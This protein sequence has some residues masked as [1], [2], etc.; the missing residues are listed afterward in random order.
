M[1]LFGGVKAP[2]RGESSF[3]AT[4]RNLAFYEGQATKYRLAFIAVGI[5]VILGGV[6]IAT[7]AVLGLDTTGVSIIGAAIVLAEASS[8]FFQVQKRY[9]DYRITAEA[10]RLAIED[11]NALKERKDRRPERAFDDL[12]EIRRQEVTKWAKLTRGI[13][14]TTAHQAQPGA[15]DDSKGDPG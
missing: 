11:F 1:G 9:V 8:Q 13:R 14:L 3:D 2:E 7:S 12:A 4:K 10:H 15:G 6:S 5:V